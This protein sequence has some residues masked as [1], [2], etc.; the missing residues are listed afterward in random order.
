[1]TGPAREVEVVVDRLVLHGVRE[2]DVDAVVHAFRSHLAVLAGGE[3][4]PADTTPERQRSR[5]RRSPPAAGPRHDE[6]AAIG[7]RAAA[8]VW[9]SAGRGATTTT[10]GH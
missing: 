6:A 1:M 7:R 8:A 3:P 9:R 10:G 2:A 5:T 4:S